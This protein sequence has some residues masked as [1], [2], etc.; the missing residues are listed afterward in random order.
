[1][2]DNL[3]KAERP[4]PR[5]AFAEVAPEGFFERPGV[6]RLRDPG[7]RPKSLL[8]GRI[9]AAWSTAAAGVLGVAPPEQP[10][11]PARSPVAD[12]L[13]LGPDEWLVLGSGS[14]IR[15]GSLAPALLRAG[16]AAAEVGDGLPDLELSGPRARDVLAGGT[17]LDLHPSAFPAGRAT[18]TRLGRIGVLLQRVEDGGDDPVFRLHVERPWAGHLWSWLADAALDHPSNDESFPR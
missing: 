6:V 4:T 9:T 3:T 17:A 5:S 18:R 16:L 10:G 12:V 2:P 8:R 14:G 13:W 7:H 1:M 15:P 11:I